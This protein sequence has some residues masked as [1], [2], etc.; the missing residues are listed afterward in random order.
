MRMTRSSYMSLHFDRD[1]VIQ[2]LLLLLSCITLYPLLRIGFV[3]GDDLEYFITASPSRWFADAQLYA[4]G[5][6]RFYFYLVKWIY[7]IP[8]LVDSRIYYLF[9]FIGPITLTF[10]LFF[11]LI[12]R[13]TKSKT[14]T[15][16][17]VLLR[18]SF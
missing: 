9:F 7:S 18:I 5:T 16:W 14:I 17:S 3:T 13:V 4:Q 2:W 12:K 10:C 11:S 8:Y 1:R 15:Y 6:G